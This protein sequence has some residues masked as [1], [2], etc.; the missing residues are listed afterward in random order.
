MMDARTP[1]PSRRDVGKAERRRRIVEA[2]AA[3]VRVSGLDNV[4]MVQIAERAEVSPATVY[5]LFQT[6]AAIFRQV[7]DLDLEDYQRRVADVP[8]RDAIERIFAAIDL[9]AS[10]YRR[11]P[12]FYRAMARGGGEATR[13]SSAISEPRK[14]FWQAQVADA[15]EEGC[16]SQ[17]TSPDLLGATLTQ[18]MRGVFLDWAGHVIST[19]RLAK[20]TAYGFAMMLRAH[21]TEEVAVALAARQKDLQATLARTGRDDGG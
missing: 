4:S 1:P 18:F 20:E 19:E 10:L 6:K 7:F 8:A 13:L 15:V 17:S 3:L 21:A 14:A 11:D 16:L 2:A 9:A 5:N 12:D